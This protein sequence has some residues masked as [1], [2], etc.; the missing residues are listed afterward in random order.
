MEFKQ[1]LYLIFKEGI[2]NAIKHSNCK[3]ISLEASLNKDFLEL[4]LKDDGSGFDKQNSVIGNG[5]LN[6]KN[7]ADSIGCELIIDSSY[8]GTTIKFVGKIRG[9]KRAFL[10]LIKP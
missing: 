1:N 10:S 2:N 3:K 5:M 6:M 4:T 8:E 7:R 9:F